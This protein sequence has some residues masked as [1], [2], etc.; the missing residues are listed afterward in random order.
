MPLRK[1]QPMKFT[2]LSIT[3]AEDG[4]NISPGSM[5][6][7]SNLIPDPKTRGV[8]QPRPAAVRLTNFP[9][10]NSPGLI[11]ALKVVG[12][13]A[14]GMIQ[15]SRFPGQEEP[16]IYDIASNTFVTLTGVTALNT[17]LNCPTT[18]DWTPPIMDLI[19]SKLVVCHPGY[20]GQVSGNAQGFIGW[21]DLT[22]F[23]APAWA[24]GNLSGQPFTVAEGVP[25][26]VANY[27][28]RAYYAVGNKV[29]F[30]DVLVPLTQTNASQ[31]LTLGDTAP[32]TA[33]VGL[34]LSA[35]S[36][37]IL[38]GLMA[39][40]GV[41]TIFQVTGDAAL[42][43]L[44]QN[45]LNISTGS[46]AP[47]SMCATPN[48]VAFVSPQGVRLIDFS[49]KVSDV[50]GLWGTGVTLP[51]ISAV[52]P[53][54][55][56]AASN[57]NLIRLSVKNGVA[58]G[59]PNEEYW[60]DTARQCWSGP[61]TFPA[62]QIEPYNNTFIIAPTA[63]LGSL[64]QSDPEVNVNSVFTENGTPL[65]FVYATTVF[66]DLETMSQYCVVETTISMALVPGAQVG[67]QALDQ[68]KGVFD[69]LILQGG[70]QSK[71]GGL[72][73]GADIWGGA[74]DTYSPKVVPWSKPLV[75]RKMSIAVSGR[76]IVGFKIGD[77]RLR[78]QVLGYLQA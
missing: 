40:K 69:S 75:F 10:F 15:T 22:T 59:Q 31:S 62:S 36:G 13:R 74:V 50:I 12:S 27:G 1:A 18:G 37:G 23:S 19:G 72:I 5:G 65:N 52:A 64:W 61:H 16:F 44:A 68:N 49:T 54:R 3:D 9:G 6:Q 43:N 32:V 20:T 46:L 76:S 4:T 42:N 11:T 70:Q 34:P 58:P 47:L 38:Q 7:L 21:F 55:I 51:F 39:F 24:S 8:W 53:S 17:P 77:T 14:Y 73:W 35:S 28:G 45:Q 78:Y 57:G 67:I 60:L 48:G 71:W 26:A 66:P 56:A 25:V 63:V 2:P 41:G 29:R 30:S 33:L